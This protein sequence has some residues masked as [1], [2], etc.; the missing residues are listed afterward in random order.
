MDSTS[1]LEAVTGKQSALDSDESSKRP[2][3]TCECAWWGK[4]CPL[5]FWD[6]EPTDEKAESDLTTTR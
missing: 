1:Q 6:D 2:A 3:L 5:F 4:P